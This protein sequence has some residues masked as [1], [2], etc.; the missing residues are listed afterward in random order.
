[1]K[2]LVTH[3]T[4]FIGA[5]LVKALLKEGYVVSVISR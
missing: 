5:V 1:M 3:A 2:V 4:G